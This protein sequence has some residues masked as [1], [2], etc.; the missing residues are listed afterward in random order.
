MYAEQSTKRN[1]NIPAGKATG[2][3][4]QEYS[5]PSPLDQLDPNS[6]ETIEVLKGPS[7]SAIYG[8]D[9]GNG[10]IVV[11]T[12]RGRGGPTSW[13][14]LAGQGLSFQ[15]GDFPVGVYRFGHYF[16]EGSRIC[17]L[18]EIHCALDSVIKF[19]ALNDP[20]YAVTSAHGFTRDVSGTVS[21]GV[22]TVVYSLT[23]SM[24]RALGQLKLPNDE[25]ERFTI[26]HNGT[27][28]PNWMR[29]PDRYGTQGGQSSLTFPLGD[30]GKQGT[31]SLSNR[32]FVSHQQQSSLQS[33]IGQLEAT[34]VDTS[35]LG[36]QPLLN[37]FYERATSD[38]LHSTNALTASWRPLSWLPVLNATAG[39][40]LMNRKSQTL[41]P[42]N[43]MPYADSVGY[44]S[45]ARNDTRMT[46]LTLGTS[47]PSRVVRTDFG[48][49]F[50]AQAFDDI[51]G[52]VQG[53]PSGV[54]IPSTLGPG[55][56]ES[57]VSTTTY[58]WYLV[59]QFNIRSR[60]FI[61]P[62][63]RLDG[64]SASGRRVSTGGIPGVNGFPKVDVSWLAFDRASQG[65]GAPSV[66][67]ALTSLRLR[68][69]FGTAGVQP[70]PG[71][72]LRLLKSSVAL[73]DG[74]PE[75]LVA[76][77][78]I[79]NTRLRPERSRELEGGFEAVF[80]DNRAGV[81]VTGW[82]K[83]RYDAI[84]SV[85]VAAS[86]LQL[87]MS[88][89]IGEIQNS[90]NDVQLTLQPVQSS[91]LSWSMATTVSRQSNHVVSLVPGLAI[92]GIPAALGNSLSNII[93]AGY[94]VNGWWAKPIQGFSDLNGDGIIT[95]DEVVIGDSLQF[96]GQDLPNYEATFNTDVTVLNGRLGF[97]TTLA[98]Q[99][100][101]TLLNNLNARDVSVGSY[102][103][104]AG[105]IFFANDP[106]IPLGQ[107]AAYAAL[108][109]NCTNG[110]DG[111]IG[112]AY[113][114]VQTVNT[115]RWQSASV[116]YNA[117][118]SWA[119]LVRARRLVFALQG[120]NLGLHTNYRGKDPNV[121]DFSTGEAVRDSGQ[122]PL[123]R[124]V[125]LQIT[126]GN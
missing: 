16:N 103:Q 117:P 38:E 76:I 37:N 30:G 116:N 69:A 31:I 89:N 44:F 81:N 111:T 7:A 14:L 101:L 28:P 109:G 41:V 87:Q 85:P 64:G 71:D 40:D 86:V 1:L 90:G 72:N 46:T 33:A 61:N 42:R 20:R 93:R 51:A 74:V 56:T 119:R 106:S 75:D 58:G 104:R 45:T 21:G 59:P 10:V 52:S 12:K 124:T 23:G 66:L 22:G 3:Q 67:R 55:G 60:L 13:S 62:G 53:I 112:T 94:P 113:G 97:H 19:Q 65:D 11:T 18:M 122:L 8:S 78:G 110:C 77:T 84:M 24:S 27:A 107:Q 49:N 39:V 17:Y 88:K 6:I 50:T 105:T 73:L 36:A 92:G 25:A 32:L 2:D 15:P 99:N 4:V 54:E 63:L 34:F 35:S 118:V 91:A 102:V 70:S 95:R 79:G 108:L 82:R 120:S 115:L 29:R 125:S 123:P 57:S 96:V 26:F 114:L 121:N 43:F 83:T 98:Y 9:A 100:G 80:W 47:I 126:L 68:G 5:M 48:F